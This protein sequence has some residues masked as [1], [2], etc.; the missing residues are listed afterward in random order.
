MF[1]AFVALVLPVAALCCAMPAHAE[2]SLARVPL[3]QAP[4]DV[5]GWDRAPRVRSQP[6]KAPG[7]EE[8]PYLTDEPAGRSFSV[9]TV[10]EGYVVNAAALTLPSQHVAVLHRQRQRDLAWATQEMI[11]LLEDS[12]ERVARDSRDGSVLWLGNIG[13][14]GGGDIPWSV[15][16]NAGRDADL[17]FY[18]TTP[19]GV[20][21]E[22][23]DLLHYDDRGRSRE[24]GGY[25]RFDAARNWLLVRAL[26]N[27]PHGRIQYLFISNGLKGLVLAE[28]RRRGEPDELIARASAVLRQPGGSLPHDD[29]L[30]LRIYCGR[31]DAGARCDDIGVAHSW[32][33]D[34][35]GVTRARAELAESLLRAPEA[36]TRVAAVRRLTFM[37]QRRSLDLIV[38]R[39]SDPSA[40][41][42]AAAARSIGQMGSD[43]D[44]A[45]LVERWEEEEDAGVRQALAEALA[46]LGGPVATAMLI[47][48][49]REV[50]PANWA[51]KPFDLRWPILD[52]LARSG[53]AVGLQEMVALL[54]DDDG[55]TR[56][57]AAR[58]VERLT[59]TAVS[60]ADARSSSS[61][62]RAQWRSDLEQ[63]QSVFPRGRDG[64]ATIR[65]RGYAASGLSADSSG[66]A[67]A[68]ALARLVASGDAWYV[69]ANARAD[70]QRM[71][72]HDP[73]AATWPDQDLSDYWSRWI[74]RN[75]GRIARR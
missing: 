59:N 56:Y 72:S 57:R 37:R 44:V 32:M 6:R 53:A 31:P 22:P 46:S 60:E 18:T 25:Y 5:L 21:V 30:H 73:R 58:A 41:V 38:R 43:G 24:Y 62:L 48:L 3:V 26:L 67:R 34:L 40:A 61:V 66:A 52:A 42:R 7:N 69:R 50:R 55:E 27:S 49:L 74:R 17:A 9:G 14:N 8:F 51:G 35:D 64:L 75:S 36:A 23:P 13:A 12:G 1:R 10:T 33:P 65:D 20:P 2:V 45:G 63:W 19:S 16:H 4:V 70:L 15:S 68:R 29:H 54:D 39:F 47:E 28:A 11:A 71:C